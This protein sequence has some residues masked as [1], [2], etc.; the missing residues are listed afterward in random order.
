MT[1]G[2]RPDRVKQPSETV[3]DEV[4]QARK[5]VLVILA[6]GLCV[7]SASVAS[8]AAPTPTVTNADQAQRAKDAA[9]HRVVSVAHSIAGQSKHI[10]ALSLT[11]SQAEQR[12]GAQQIVQ[13]DAEYDEAMARLQ[14]SAAQVQYREAYNAF[15]AAAVS[16]YES[17]G[18][19]GSIG[20]SSVGAL[21]I[22]DDP[23][24]VL[25]AGTQQQ[26]LA[27]HQA[28]VVSQMTLALQAVHSAEKTERGTLANVGRQ[29]AR[30][31]AIRRQ[32]E[33]ALAGGRVALKRLQADLVKAKD[34]QKQADAVLSTFLGGW[35]AADPA[36]AAAVNQQY[37][38]IARQVA[39]AK[40]AKHEAHWTAGMGQTVVN[41]ALQY[42]ATPYAWA[43]GALSGPTAGV[44]AA[45]SAHND[46]HLTGFDCSGLALYAWGLYLAMA[47]SAATQY[48]SGTV[49]PAVTAL[50]PGD[51]VFWSS[52]HT[53]AG[54]H[55][56]AIYVG[57]GN[58]IQA[59]QSGDIVRITPLANVSSGYFGATRPL[60]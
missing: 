31:A 10:A 9:D 26:M 59:P 21:L 39:T 7:G 27:D 11:A 37:E 25:N 40:P 45:G 48:G 28:T 57:S 18:A 14:V 54:I 52:N 24:D 8:Y 47:H 15:A 20:T 13:A 36:R 55:H 32:A 22:N 33:S 58:V 16:S 38:A 51:L 49:H 30:L 56:V 4:I 2:I 43:G 50:L 23:S 34:T 3:V 5:A 6:A 17:G 42:L 60:S 35:S 1:V 29:T 44:C 19:P 46:C 53:V 12:F 41:R